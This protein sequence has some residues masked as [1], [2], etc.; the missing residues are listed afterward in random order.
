MWYQVKCFPKIEKD[1]S[2]LPAARSPTVG[3]NFLT[4]QVVVQTFL[5]GIESEILLGVT[6]I[7]LGVYLE[8]VV[9][10]LVDNYL[11]FIYL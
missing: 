9:E 7:S 6:V 4:R 3:T 5:P 1:S 2:Y 8:P 11:D 10:K